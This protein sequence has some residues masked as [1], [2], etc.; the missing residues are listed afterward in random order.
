[1]KVLLVEPKYYTTYPPLPLLKL[2]SWHKRQGHEVQLV[3]GCV[4]QVI[5]ASLVYVT[6]LFTYAWKPVMDA[7]W[8]YRSVLP[9][10]KIVLGGI[11]ASILPEHAIEHCKPD[12]LV[13]GLVD[14]LEG[15][16]LLPD[17]SLVE[18]EW[19]DGSIVCASRGCI[20]NCD[21]CAVPKI[22]GHIKS[23]QSIR[24]LIWSGHRKV[25]FWDNNFL[26][27]ENWRDILAEVREL[28]FVVDF[29][30]GLDA[31]LITP[32]VAHEL[33]KSRVEQV[34]MSYDTKGQGKA[35][36]RAIECLREAGYSGRRVI[37]YVLYNYN[38]TPHDFWQRVC[39][40]LSA[41]VVVYPM[42]YESLNSLEKGQYIDKGWS[43]QEIE[44]VIKALRVMGIHGAFPPHEGLIKKITQAQDFY[45]AF[46]L[47][48]K[49]KNKSQLCL[50]FNA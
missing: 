8:Y 43:K 17:Y 19:N 35:V 44:M 10:A 6:S 16:D 15:D 11:Y 23:R 9:K 31:R 12:E 18:P 4:S 20:R 26:A 47:N 1:M 13:T 3:K 39:E 49:S 29:N 21:F 27:I 48:P 34:R 41:G 40:L 24:K 28:N 45:Q 30:Q 37:V 7:I 25:I 32:E 42:R 33:K 22:E 14:Y 5:D 38:S 46:S 50:H 36:L 2:A